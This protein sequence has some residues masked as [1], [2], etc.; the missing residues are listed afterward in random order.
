MNR[1]GRRGRLGAVEEIVD[2]RRDRAEDEAKKLWTNGVHAALMD[3][4][5]TNQ[6][7]QWSD[8]IWT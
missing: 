8:D 5:E 4:A 3:A 6:K 7:N 2:P 1:F